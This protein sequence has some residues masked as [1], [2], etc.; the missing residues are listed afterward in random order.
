MTNGTPQCSALKRIL[1]EIKGALSAG[2]PIRGKRYL[3]P[4]L[5]PLTKINSKY[6]TESM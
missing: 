2:Y 6:I 3:D 4:L 1:V 5:T